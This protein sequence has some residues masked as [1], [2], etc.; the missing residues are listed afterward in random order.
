ML[1]NSYCTKQMACAWERM[2]LPKLSIGGLKVQ[3][4][5]CSA[6]G[7]NEHHKTIHELQL[8]YAK[9]CKHMH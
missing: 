5:W 3:M 6:A 1:S 9:P 8:S 2:M 4:L 7:Q